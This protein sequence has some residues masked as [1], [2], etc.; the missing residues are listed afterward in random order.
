M[1]IRALANRFYPLLWR[2]L[3]VAGKRYLTGK[4]QQRRQMFS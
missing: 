1:A 4:S 2:R 3:L